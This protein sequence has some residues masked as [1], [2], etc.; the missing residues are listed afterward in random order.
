MR[1]GAPIADEIKSQ[2]LQARSFPSNR[3]HAS[4]ATPVVCRKEP[5]KERTKPFI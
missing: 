2:L 3:I 4:R 5:L 1:L